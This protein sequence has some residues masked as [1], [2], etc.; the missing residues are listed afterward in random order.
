MNI[1]VLEKKITFISTTKIYYVIKPNIFSVKIF[2][3]LFLFSIQF[4]SF[5]ILYT[6]S[7]SSHFIN[8]GIL[9]SPRSSDVICVT[10][11]AVS[12]LLSI[13]L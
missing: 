1:G 2:I 5:F 4:I 9:W 13:L 11:S 3:I 10:V 7:P 8:N 6:P 12:W